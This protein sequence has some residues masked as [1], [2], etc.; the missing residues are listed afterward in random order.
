MPASSTSANDVSLCELP[1]DRESLLDRA[2]SQRRAIYDTV[3]GIVAGLEEVASWEVLY[4]PPTDGAALAR[5]VRSLLELVDG[6]P[7]K[8]QAL[9][10]ELES[11]GLDSQ[12]LE[13][14]D[15][16]FGGIHG[17]VA[18]DLQ[19]LRT[20]LEELEDHFQ[21]TAAQRAYLCEIAA[22]IKGKYGSA[23][24]GAASSLITEGLWN[25]VQAEP[26]LFPEKA[27]E[28][29]RNEALVQAID[30]VRS[31]I[32]L[33]PRS[34]P[35]AD[36][37]EGWRRHERLDRYVL[38]DLDRLKSQLGMLLKA[39]NRRAL[40]SGDFH[41]IQR[42]EGLLS[43]RL[44][45]LEA[46]H[47]S[48]WTEGKDAVPSATYE[49][50][51]QLVLEVAAIIDV[52]ILQELIGG[53][54]CRDL[55]AVV[56][57][58]RARGGPSEMGAS[59][60]DGLRDLVPLLAED[61]LVT[62]FGALRG[63]VL[64][65]LS[66]K[67][68]TE[69][70]SRSRVET[71]PRPTPSEPVASEDGEVLSAIDP[72]GAEAER[73]LEVEEPEAEQPASA[74][75]VSGSMAALAAAR[76]CLSAMRSTTNPSWKGFLMVERMLTRHGRIPPRMFGL[77]APLIEELWTRLIP[78]LEEVARCDDFP[79]STVEKLRAGCSDLRQGDVSS[80][81]LERT[82]PRALRTISEALEESTAKITELV[83]NR[84]VF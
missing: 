7:E 18:A 81:T 11:A 52:A 34:L 15:F 5:L 40:Y 76:D 43:E 3:R 46:L 63:A 71:Q 74:S 25:S 35:F 69:A 36:L 6:V 4:A 82:I 23:V 56:T 31:T 80:A 60:P 22:D 70:E 26:I 12:S 33:L 79:Q 62:Y 32:E 67:A 1:P 49:R 41:Q 68:D 65:R 38:A 45:E 42:R 30:D 72:D 24:M 37:L 14:V 10:E 16:F 17:M 27:A 59:L 8:I 73:E 19:R 50:L 51:A 47:R 57:T 44:N 64:K 77:A 83:V 61:D 66:L 58:E 54:R 28:F 84:S 53:R 29:Q 2:G 20:K 48:T 55:R 75:R 9:V 13:D 21:S 78:L 39:S